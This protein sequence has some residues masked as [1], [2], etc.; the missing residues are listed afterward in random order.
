MALS[1]C[2]D[3]GSSDASGITADHR[4][5][6]RGL[7]G[8]P[9]SLDPQRAEDAFSYDVLRDL[10]EGLVRSDPEGNVVPAVAE[11]WDVSAD[12]R[13]YTFALRADA[14]WSNGDPVTAG[15]F[16]AALR[17]ALDPATASGAADLL[18]AIENAPEILRGQLPPDRLGVDAPDAYSLEI[19]LARPVAYFPDILTNTVVSP[20]HVSTLAGDGGFSR[21]GV[22][23]TNG[24]YRLAALAPGASLRLVRNPHY[25]DKAS[26]AYDEIRYE[27]FPD[28][29]AEFARFRAGEL[30]V[31]NSVPEQR[32]EDLARTAGSGLQ[33]RP[34]L[35]TF[36]FTFNTDRGPL[37]GKPALR[38]ALSLAV[39]RETITSAITR[40]GQVPAY[41]LVPDGVWNYEPARYDWSGESRDARL[42][43][44]RSLYAAAGFTPQR[45]LQLRLLYN[46]NELVQRVCVAIAAMWKE[47]LG[48]ETE[49]V[50][51]EFKAYLA[52]R[53]DPA[54]WDVV[55]VGWTA[56]YNDA[57]TFLDTMLE[58]SPQNFGRWSDARYARL[59]ESAADET[60][61]ARRRETLQQAEALMLQDYPLLP[62]YVYVTRRLVHPL[63][64]APPIN[65]LNRTYSRDF[66]PAG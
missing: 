57:S 59:M 41:A 20:V 44:A 50:Q 30:D 65:P 48:V 40:A 6:R 58:G 53:A 16:V 37:R 32:F 51:M 49:L 61:A 46:Q 26:V 7:G 42:A 17:R 54:Q 15:D 12:G 35:A 19:R 31:T 2:A 10:Y 29:N 22:T 8:Q 28:E 34:T 4:V 5:L 33:H 62:A 47:S 25:W 21:P 9:G 63:V 39:D 18:R 55:R 36:Y 45:P 27:F 52:A 43:R 1:S 38:E 23:V 60:D 3:R 64:Q 24:P 11:S 14:R 56:D 13:R 66:R